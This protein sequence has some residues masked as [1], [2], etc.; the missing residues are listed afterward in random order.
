MSEDKAYLSFIISLCE[1]ICH[2]NKEK[3][4]KLKII[5]NIKY[6]YSEPMRSHEETAKE[7][8]KNGFKY[9]TIEQSIRKICETLPIIK[10]SPKNETNLKY[11]LE[12]A[13]SQFSYEESEIN[14]DV[15]DPSDEEGIEYMKGIDRVSAPPRK[16]LCGSEQ[17]IDVPL[18]VGRDEL[19]AELKQELVGGKKV[20]AIVGQGGMGKT[21]LAIKSIE[22]VGVDLNAKTLTAECPYEYVL[23]H[24]VRENDGFDTVAAALL[25]MVAPEVGASSVPRETIE[26]IIVGL[27][28]YRCLVVLD[29]LESL[30]REGTGQS[31]EP[32]IDNLLNR[33][34]DGG[35]RSQIIITS[36]ELTKGLADRRGTRIDPK[37]V[38]EIIIPGISE[39]ASIDL[40]K[41][42]GLTDSE[43]DL[44]WIAERVGGNALILTFLADIGQEQPGYLRQ[45]PD[46]VCDEATP[47]IGA[48]FDRQSGD[49]REL[50]RRMC[51]LRIG[52]NAEHLATLR[53][54]EAG[55][56]VIA[57]TKEQ[58][59]KTKALLATLKGCGLVESI[60]DPVVCQPFY[61][62]HRLVQE[63]L[64]DT[65]ED[66]LPNLYRY[67]ARFYSSFEVQEEYKNLDEFRFILEEFYFHWQLERSEDVIDIVLSIIVPK[68]GQWSY[69][70]LLKEWC[71]RVLPHTEGM[72]YRNCIN[73]LG[74]I[75]RDTGDW[76]GAEKYFK[77]SLAHAEDAGAMGGIGISLGLLGYIQ[78]KRGKDDAAEALY[79]QSLQLWTELGDRAGMAS[80]WGVLG[81]LQ[82]KRGNCD[83]AEALYQQC[84]QVLT[85]L[86]D[87]AGMATSWGVLGDIERKR[88]NYD[89]AEALYQQ[90]LQVLTELGDRAG[91]ATSIGCL[92]E[93][94][95]LRGNLDFAEPLL[96]DAL[97]RMEAL[98]IPDSIAEANWDLAKLYRAKHSPSQAQS[99]FDRA[100][101]LYTQLG[102]KADLAKIE[103]EWNSET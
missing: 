46:L 93:T 9:N 94:E 4:D 15:F 53:L 75:C 8:G 65:F 67:A 81:D 13:F 103:Q 19:L 30:L 40:L 16:R 80:S 68:L 62:L 92:G 79:Q 35:H 24:T 7:I 20:I 17:I 31:I 91:M 21:S 52:T 90:S 102:A 34:V 84:L 10:S 32:D 63:V 87:R 14:P 72:N 44:A 59:R 12:T 37:F 49:G 33:L 66:D 56:E 29:N 85:E 73:T 97:D 99:H 64:V 96:L 77:L 86:D 50:L 38:K 48:Q 51:V 74:C 18:W 95:L 55:G 47:V 61:T 76:D 83:A 43:D 58:V 100:H 28:K 41:Q 5:L 25:D 36:R 98:Q 88:G 60:Y 89:A 42:L 39:K 45:N 69:W 54:I 26:R 1:A 3:S 23:F 101:Q 78:S 71:D 6:S 22:S 2:G 57:A 82:R 70:S 11:W 27:N